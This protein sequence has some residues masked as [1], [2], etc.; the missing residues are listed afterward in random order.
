[1]GH[2]HAILKCEICSAVIAQCR[3]ADPNKTVRLSRCDNCA[4]VEQAQASRR[5]HPTATI[6]PGS[7]IF[8]DVRIGAHS[9][10]D[11]FVLIDGRRAPVNIG[12]YVHVGGYASIVGGAVEIEDFAG[13]SLGARIFAANDVPHRHLTNPTVPPE[14]RNTLRAKVHLERHALVG[15]NSVVMP[16]AYLRTGSVVGAS[17]FVPPGKVL[18]EWGIYAGCPVRLVGKRV[19]HAVLELESQLRNKQEKK[20]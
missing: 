6:H 16:G 5:A 2:E 14:Y 10:I 13:L 7:A 18:D 12:D 3:C 9:G 17:S 4:K 15:A 11:S 20:Q 1:M 19:S 8:G